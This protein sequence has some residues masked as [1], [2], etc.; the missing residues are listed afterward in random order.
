MKIMRLA[1]AVLILFLPGPLARYVGNRMGYRIAPTARI[2]LSWIDVDALEMA[3]GAIIGHGNQIRGP[4]SI[5]MDSNAK[6]GHFNTVSRARLGISVGAATLTMGIWSAVT[7]RH[8]LDLCQSIHIGH[9]S[10]VA[11]TGSQLWTHGYVHERE[12]LGRYRI[13][14]AIEIGDNV[15]VGT[16]CFISMGVRIASGAIIGGGS[17][18]AK[19]IAEPGLYVSSP[20]RMLPRPAEPDTRDDLEPLDKALSCDRVYRKRNAR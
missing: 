9:Y 10:T 20:L 6:L 19:D 3:D 1:R 8:R 18:I 15:Y 4:F 2:G 14:G 11:G 5:M 7:A 13:D 17:A 12:G 16:M